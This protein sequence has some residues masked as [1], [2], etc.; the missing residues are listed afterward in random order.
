MMEDYSDK[1]SVYNFLNQLDE[2]NKLVKKYLSNL[3]ELVAE[4]DALL[5][6]IL[7]YIKFI[8]IVNSRDLKL[9]HKLI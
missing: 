3:E 6:N 4:K 8:N 5:M 2:M 7:S 1:Q 9:S